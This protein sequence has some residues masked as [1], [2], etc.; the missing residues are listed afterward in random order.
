MSLLECVW[1]LGRCCPCA[2]ED[3]CFV[4][5]PHL[6]LVAAS[7]EIWGQIWWVLA[8]GMGR[9]EAVAPWGLEQGVLLELGSRRMEILEIYDGGI[10]DPLLLSCCME[11]CA[12]CSVNSKRSMKVL[13]RGDGSAEPLCCG[14][15]L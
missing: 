6:L 2:Y 8:V 9:T 13:R 15:A 10:V 14:G 4:L 12:L 3:F 7:E 11:S 5:F 1:G